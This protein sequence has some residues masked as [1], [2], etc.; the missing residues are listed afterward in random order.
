MEKRKRNVLSELSRKVKDRE[1]RRLIEEVQVE[2]DSMSSVEQQLI[3][4]A[5]TELVETGQ[6]DTL[7]AVWDVDYLRKPVSVEKLLDDTYYFGSLTKD[8]YPIWRKEIIDIFSPRKQVS[9]VI[10]G[11]C[12]GSGKTT[13]A[14]ICMAIQ[15]YYI[16][17]LRDPHAYYGLIKGSTIALGIY[18]VTKTQAQDSSFAK[19]MT[20][21]SE[22]PYF[23]E[24]YP[25]NTR[26]KS[27]IAFQKGAVQVICGSNELHAIG[28]DL[29]SFLLDEANFLRD[30]R[31]PRS[32]E[33]SVGEAYKLYNGARNRVRSRFMRKGGVT[34][35]KVFLI[36]SKQTH[37]AFLEQHVE[38]VSDEIHK[39]TVKLLE[40]SRWGILE[41]SK[42]WKDLGLNRCGRFRVE[43]GDQIYP[44]RVI[45][46][47]EEA[48]VDAGVIEVP[49][50]Y[51]N[52]FDA[53]VD[54]ALR[55]IAGIATY[56]IS[57]L[58]HNKRVIHACIDKDLQH[59]FTRD[60][61]SLDLENDIML[62]TFFLPERM[63]V[64]RRSTYVPKL[65]PWAPRFIHIDLGLTG[66]C[67]GIGC[68]HPSGFKEVRRSRG[69]GTYYI[70]KCPQ[71]NVDFV[72]RILPPAG[73]EID[74]SKIRSFII[75]LKDM[76][77]PI[78]KVTCDGFSSRDMIQ[79]MRKIG[80]DSHVFSVDRN[81]TPY[82]HLRQAY[83]E[84][85]IHVYDYKPLT[86]ELSDLER[87]IEKR[88][89]DHPHTSP[90]TGKAGSKDVSDGL[91]GAVTNCIIDPRVSTA[92]S[93]QEASLTSVSDRPN[94]SHTGQKISSSAG[95]LSWNSIL[96]E[97]RR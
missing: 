43:L 29:I 50:L 74:I 9:E 44:S 27:K 66:D 16:S 1:T 23:K 38:E 68:V 40:Y 26:I 76:G 53:D 35:G 13:V 70:D 48:R 60:V 56:G 95:D 46:E 17:C 54:Q 73:S 84:K 96:K 20:Y 42:K 31:K 55:D 25:H 90:I 34:P 32:G 4:Q 21:V 88:K 81:D 75:Y 49:V 12:I 97:T 83:I 94:G 65:N 91:A 36:S 30:P 24:N 41:G 93:G 7:R 82:L 37:R 87:D 80:L 85:R 45:P 14:C 11:G 71:I 86:I 39:G 8:L 59:P 33:S 18:S 47:G 10:F 64:I 19:I 15:L 57:P 52:E 6:S 61:L 72:L 69:D 51:W 28:L 3:V 89:V 5:I 77:L 92:I 67:A 78:V 62:D 22:S 58:F 2:F 79:I 63:F